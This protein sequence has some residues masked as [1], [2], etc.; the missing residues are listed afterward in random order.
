MS[1]QAESFPGKKNWAFIHENFSFKRAYGRIK[2]LRD[3]E[4]IIGAIPPF[5]DAKIAA[6]K[7]VPFGFIDIGTD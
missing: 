7:G 1:L 6:Q 2:E 3:F 5:F 4:T